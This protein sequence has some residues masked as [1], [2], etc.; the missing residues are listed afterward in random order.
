FDETYRADG[1]DIPDEKRSELQL[2]VARALIEDGSLDRARTAAI[3]N[4]GYHRDDAITET[5][6]ALV[7]AGRLPDA[8]ELVGQLKDQDEGRLALAFALGD[9]HE[10]AAALELAQ[11]IDATH[12]R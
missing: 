5:A 8:L 10:T 4:E 2:H 6:V 3:K 11:R 9:M 7:K 12:Y 1:I